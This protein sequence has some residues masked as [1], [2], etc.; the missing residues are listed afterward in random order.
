MMI[1]EFRR[2]G[3]R[4]TEYGPP[5]SNL[6]S[7]NFVIL[8]VFVALWYSLVLGLRSRIMVQYHPL[9]PFESCDSQSTSTPAWRPAGLMTSSLRLN[10]LAR[11][12][13]G[14]SLALF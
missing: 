2:Y 8:C 11:M 12:T 7:Q 6:Q 13:A 14:Y 3:I 10:Q 5:I 4:N 9:R 1:K